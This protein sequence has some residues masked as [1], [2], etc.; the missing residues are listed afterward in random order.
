MVAVQPRMEHDVHVDDIAERGV[1]D[2]WPVGLARGAPRHL[3]VL[4]IVRPGLCVF[5]PNEAVWLMAA[6]YANFMAS[7]WPVNEMLVTEHGWFDFM[8]DE[9]GLTPAAV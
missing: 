9:A 4:V 7:L 6:R 2:G 1:V 8:T 3:P 5:G